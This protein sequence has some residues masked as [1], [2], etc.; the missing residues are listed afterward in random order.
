MYADYVPN[1]IKGLSS[2]IADNNTEQVRMKLHSLKTA[3]SYMGISAA[4]EL[5]EAI[6]DNIEKHDT[7]NGKLIDELT[8]IWNSTLPKIQEHVKRLVNQENN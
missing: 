3:F 5:T 1:D 4:S 8:E 2:A 6:G 7:D